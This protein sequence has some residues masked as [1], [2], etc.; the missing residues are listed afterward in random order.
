MTLFGL[1]GFSGAGKGSVAQVISS[2]LKSAQI[3]STGDTVRQ[4]L[5][6]SGSELN[7]DNL[8]KLNN[9]LYT[10]LQDKYIGIIYEFLDLNAQYIIV[11]SLRTM[12]DFEKLTK[13]FGIVRLVGVCA[14][15][16]VRFQR[17]KG[18]NRETDPKNEKDFR[19]LTQQEEYWGV[20]GLLNKAEIIIDNNGTLQELENKISEQISI[21]LNPNS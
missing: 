4:L 2:K 13:D 3:V 5:K 21:L 7:Y 12:V 9:Q 1:C 14:T 11:D 20:S 17:I 10:T 8:Q 16:Q 18:R 15:E 6:R 19:K